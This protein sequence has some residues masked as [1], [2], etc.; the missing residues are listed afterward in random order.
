MSALGRV[1]D[2]FRGVPFL[3]AFAV[4]AFGLLGCDSDKD[5]AK[6]QPPAAPSRVVA[7]APDPSD[8]PTLSDFCDVHRPSQ[9]APK[10][11]W[12]EMTSEPPELHGPAWVN[13]WATWCGPCVKEL[14]LVIEWNERWQQQG[15]SVDVVFVSVDE[16]QAAVDQFL[17]K[18]QLHFDTL[19]VR[20]P[21]QLPTWLES[22]GMDEG[23]TVPIHVF[24]DSLGKA[25]CV[26]TGSVDEEDVSLVTALLFD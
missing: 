19:R 22:M 16:E 15:R 21:K 1:P 5:K 2:V 3:V 11:R 25:L 9:E 18:Q 4:I 13:V 6:E 12:P 7:V 14:P 17:E 26:R 23:A 8:R 24:V 10:L 20:D